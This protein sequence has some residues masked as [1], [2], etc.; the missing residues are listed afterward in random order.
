MTVVAQDWSTALDVRSIS[1]SE[2]PISQES[3]D[4]QV[5]PMSLDQLYMYECPNLVRVPR[6]LSHIRRIR[7][8]YLM[9]N[10]I[11]SIA[12]VQWPMSL[13]FLAIYENNITSL[14]G[15]IFPPHVELIALNANQLS[16]RP[17]RGFSWPHD[18]Q[19]LSLDNQQITDISSESWPRCMTRLYM[20]FNQILSIDGQ[21]WYVHLWFSHYLAC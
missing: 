11:T 14:D 2:T 17:S 20:E 7:Q 4:A 6:G 12:G 15:V 9:E 10:A 21:S 19:A 1:F 13:A 18:L 16:G 3:A 8:V 5:W